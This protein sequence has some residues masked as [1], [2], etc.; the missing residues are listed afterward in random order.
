ML[1]GYNSQNQI[2]QE[3]RDE[4]EELVYSRRAEESFR[5]WRGQTK[6]GKLK[7]SDW[8]QRVVERVTLFQG[9]FCFGVNL[10]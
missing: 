2:V 8:G 7:R 1:L 3:N 10:R 9:H 6:N 5:P 4:T